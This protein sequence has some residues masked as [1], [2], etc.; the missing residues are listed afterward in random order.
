MSDLLGIGKTGLAVSKKALET[1]SHNISNANTDGY[2][3][4]RVVQTTNL[5]IMRGGHL[6]GSGAR[7]KTIERI[8]EQNLE[9]R[10]QANING[11]HTAKERLLQLEQVEGILNENENEGLNQIFAKFFNAFKDLSNQPE[12]ETIRSVVR[13]SANLAVSDIRRIRGSLD[14]LATNIDKKLD[15]SITDVNQILNSIAALNKKIAS[16]ESLGDMTGDFRD[17]RDSAIRAL[18]EYVKVHTYF[19]NKNHFNVDAVGIGTLVS[20]GHVAEL[21]IKPLNKDDSPNQMGGAYAIVFKDKSSLDISSKFKVGKLGSL[22]KVRDED[23]FQL[24]KEIDSI[25]FN[26]SNAVNSIHK[27]GYINKPL[28]LDPETGTYSSKDGKPVTEIN[29]FKPVDQVQN[30]ANYITLS[31]EV[32]SDLSN[33]ASALVPNS[34]GDNRISIAISKLGQAKIMNDGTTTLEEAY[35]KSIGRVGVQTGKT[36]LDLDH[37]EALMAQTKSLKERITGVSIDEEAANLVR[38]QHAY[39]ASAKVLKTAEE[40]FQ[41]VIDIKR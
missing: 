15:S 4:Q 12:N 11:N 36:R 2:S 27:Q 24:Q 22:I 6:M 16:L 38:Y 40:M 26:F 29:F 23:I 3:R 31:E 19:D 17:Q 33:I 1:T 32:N 7:I 5:P 13:D 39:E 18:S 41:T 20:A 9:N 28:T 14:N 8:E 30:A 35:L 10:L 21:Q 25:A 37:E 34:P